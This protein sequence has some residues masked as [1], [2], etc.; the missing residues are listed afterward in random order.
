MRRRK[1]R[2]AGILAGAILMCVTLAIGQARIVD[3]GGAVE[4]VR[5][6]RLIGASVV[7]LSIC[8]Q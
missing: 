3:R 4:T 6:S 8:D 2:V 5:D 7:R 1:V